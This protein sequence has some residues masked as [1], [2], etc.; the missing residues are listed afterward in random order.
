MGYSRRDLLRRACG[1]CVQCGLYVT[2]G[3]RD[4]RF[5]ARER[6]ARA[7]ARREGVGRTPRAP[8]HPAPI[9]CEIR[10]LRTAHG[11]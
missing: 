5:C 6:E 1:L 3:R 8:K 7:K 4:C 11:D 10:I 2:G 9:L